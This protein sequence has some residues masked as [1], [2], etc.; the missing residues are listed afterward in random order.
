[1]KNTEPMF[2]NVASFEKAKRTE[3]AE[4]A[5]LNYLISQNLFPE[6]ARTPEPAKTG[7][8]IPLR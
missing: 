6:S 2:N 4:R 1:M 3:D 8:V 7:R 5:L